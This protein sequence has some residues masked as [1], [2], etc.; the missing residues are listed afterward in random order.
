MASELDQIFEI[1]S[2]EKG[3]ENVLL[4][5]KIREVLRFVRGPA[6]LDIGCGV[7]Y[8]CQSLVGSADRIV[9]L[10]GSPAKI[11]RARSLNHSTTV[12]YVCSMFDAWEPAEPFDSILATNVLE[13]VSDARGF[14]R[15]CRSFLV[16]GGRMIVTVPNALGLHKRL[17]K[18]MGLIDDFY[19]LTPADLA[20]GHTRIYDR[21]RLE[22]DFRV[23]G[24]DIFHSGGILLKPLSHQQM[25][26]WDPLTVDALY[27]VGKE[28]PDYCSSLLLVGTRQA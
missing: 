16:P 1:Y 19:A 4:K 9:G 12:E 27:E 25:E 26:S 21:G 6:I 5:Y 8:L 3:F 17:G 22:E 28:L 20:K 14:L 18:A 7:G 23:S 13:H 2:E 24:F 10:D 15:R 11:A